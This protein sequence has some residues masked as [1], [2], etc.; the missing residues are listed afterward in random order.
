MKLFWL[1]RTE[2]ET[3]VSGTGRVAEGAVFSDGRVVMR[4]CTTTASTAFY[5][6]I[7]DVEEIHGHGGKTRVEFV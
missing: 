3:G 4:W 2:D 1:N 6:C 7:A 5:D